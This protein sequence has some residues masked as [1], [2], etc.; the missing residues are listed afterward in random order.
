MAQWKVPDLAIAVVHDDAPILV[1][2]FGQCDVEAGLPVTA[3]S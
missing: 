3:D 2:T 1:K